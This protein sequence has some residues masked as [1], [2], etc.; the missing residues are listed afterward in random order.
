MGNL[1]MKTDTK[2]G[3]NMPSLQ[4][5]VGTNL[6]QSQCVTLASEHKWNLLSDFIKFL[7]LT[8]VQVA[9]QDERLH[10]RLICRPTLVQLGQWLKPFVMIGTLLVATLT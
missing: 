8:L 3:L 1:G 6:Y 10:F 2:G 4:L 9:F 7:F 5:S